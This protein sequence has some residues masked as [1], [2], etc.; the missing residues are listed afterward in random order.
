MAA[1]V[2]ATAQDAP[3]KREAFRVCQDPN[4]L[5]FSNTNAEGIENRIA[6]V[7]GKALGL[8]VQ[9]YDYADWERRAFAQG[10]LEEHF[11]ARVLTDIVGFRVLRILGQR[12]DVVQIR[13]M[14]RKRDRELLVQPGIDADDIQ[15]IEVRHRR[16]E[17]GLG[18][19]AHRVLVGTRAARRRFE[20]ARKDDGLGV[21]VASKTEHECRG[22]TMHA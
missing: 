11:V 16:A 20:A 1:A 14:L 8:P 17:G 4:N 6:E 22:K 13:T 3:P 2:P 19:E 5:P 7:F 10:A 12:R 21:G 18:Q 15:M 9:Y